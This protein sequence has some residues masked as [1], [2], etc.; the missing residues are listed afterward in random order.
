MRLQKWYLAYT[1]SKAQHHVFI[2]DSLTIL[3]RQ[4]AI[5]AHVDVFSYK[6]AAEIAAL[7]RYQMFHKRSVLTGDYKNV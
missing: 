6:D 4:I 5:M 2:W 3:S 1:D 7:A